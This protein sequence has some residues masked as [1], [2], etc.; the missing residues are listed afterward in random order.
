E[1]GGNLTLERRLLDTMF[2]RQVD[3][4]ILASMLT[5]GRELPDHLDRSPAVLLNI[6]SSGTTALPT[7]LPAEFQAGRDAATALIEAG[8]TDIHLIGAGPGIN[9]VRT[10]SSAANDRLAGIL[11]AMG[12]HG[13]VPASG[14]IITQWL[15]PEGFRAVSDLL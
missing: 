12:E 8:H 9:D 13:I 1:T 3:G 7:V 10:M 2:D 14:H 11:A 5:H 6:G 4:L 15:P